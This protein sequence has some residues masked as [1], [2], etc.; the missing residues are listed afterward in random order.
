[1]VDF[2]SITLATHTRPEI[3]RR[4][5]YTYGALQQL[6]HQFRRRPNRQ[7]FVDSPPRGAKADDVIRHRIIELR[8]QNQSIGTEHG[9][10][11]GFEHL[12][13]ASSGRFC[14]ASVEMGQTAR[15]NK[16]QFRAE[17]SHVEEN[18]KALHGSGEGCHFA[19]PS[20]RAHP[21]LG[22]V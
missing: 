7:F 3:A 18:P 4:R 21:Y 10:E 8:K 22:S 1:M 5:G 6:V 16:L 17:V 14:F 15:S 12:E 2:T 9:I 19:S 20:S 11:A 13:K